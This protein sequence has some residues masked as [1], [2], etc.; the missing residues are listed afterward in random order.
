M[1]QKLHE[2]REKEFFK[3]NKNQMLLIYLKFL[4]GTQPP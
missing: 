1:G 4:F 2:K 3:A